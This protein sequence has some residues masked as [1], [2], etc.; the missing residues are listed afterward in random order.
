MKIINLHQTHSLPW[1]PAASAIVCVGQQL[2]L[3]GDSSQYLH[4]I[5]EKGEHHQFPLLPDTD[6]VREPLPKNQKADFE[7]LILDTTNNTLLVLPSGSKKNRILGM[8]IELP[9]TDVAYPQYKKSQI[10]HPI[11]FSPLF[12]RVM[13]YAHINEEDFNIEGGGQWGTRGWF[14]LNR[15]NGPN[16]RNLIVI[17]EGRDLSEGLPV[18]QYALDLPILQKGSDDKRVLPSLTDGCIVDDSLY[19]VA[20]AEAGASTYH[21]GEVIGSLIARYD[22]T[23]FTLQAWCLLPGNTKFEGI[24]AKEV[25]ARS[26]RLTLALCADN[27]DPTQAGAVYQTCLEITKMMQSS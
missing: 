21:D 24:S 18:A 10:A 2:F 7:S 23:N 9:K 22:L 4:L 8:R 11:D 19:V 16:A 20:A 25:S 27:D 1:L 17:L 14:L 3:I 26:T 13:K 15:G 5:D 12:D 6:P